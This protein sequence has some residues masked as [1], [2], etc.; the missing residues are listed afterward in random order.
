MRWFSK[1]F[2]R[3]VLSAMH[4]S[5][6]GRLLT[7]LTRG[8]GV[9]FM[10]HS[11][12]REPQHAYG[13]NRAL[14]VT[15]EFL[16]TVIRCTRDAGFEFASMDE[17]PHRL[18]SANGAPFA[19][20]TLDDG[21]RDNIDYAYPLFHRHGIP[22]TIYVPTEFAEGRGD[23][24]WFNLEH[25]IARLDEFTLLIGGRSRTFSCPTPVS[26]ET[27][28]NTVY[29]WLR[30]QPEATLRAIV[31]DLTRRAGLAP[32]AL[33]QQWLLN[34]DEL[35]SLAQDPLVTI[36]AHTRSHFALSQLSEAGV[37]EEV[38]A[39]RRIL[40]HQ[41]DRL[42]R[43]FSFPYGDEL[44]CG[45]RDFKAVKDLGFATAVTTREGLLQHRHVDD[46]HA[47][48]RLS[49]NGDFQQGRYVEVLLSGAP[50]AINDAASRWFS[51]PQPGVVAT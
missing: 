29:W 13:P 37:R 31:A 32:R 42:C 4:Y 12:N 44:S 48:P 14:R 43:H 26:K 45:P 19:A 20:F 30:E 5:G 23:L 24:W 46:L 16:E 3:G 27:A 25:A 1:R 41:L 10:L 9:I 38:L 49:L 17:V 35:R 50:F 21:Y 11:V 36:G 39:G 15:P 6:A 2:L 7:P 34:W 51:R 47:L 40:E 22:F 8:R 18:A 33:G 28:F